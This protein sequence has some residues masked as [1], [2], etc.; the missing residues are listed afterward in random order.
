MKAMQSRTYSATVLALASACLLAVAPAAPAAEP[1]AKETTAKDVGKKIGDAGKSVKDFSIE[2]RDEAVKN[3]KAALDDLDA[4]IRRLSAKI[5]REWDSMDAATRRKS[6][7]T[8][9]ALNRQRNE[10]AEWYG[11]LKHSSKEAW[12]E[13]KGG[14]VKSYDSLKE[15]LA[16]AKDKF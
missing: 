1:Q 8:L 15:S 5:E 10:A 16:K 13:V 9:E 6:R 3:A 4:R 7:E 12:E 2:Q 11:G 14:F